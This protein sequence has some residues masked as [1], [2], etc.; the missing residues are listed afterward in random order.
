M[1]EETTM[2]FMTYFWKPFFIPFALSYLHTC[3]SYSMWEGTIQ[4]VGSLWSSQ[5]SST[6]LYETISKTN[7]QPLGNERQAQYTLICLDFMDTH[8]TCTYIHI[9][10]WRLFEGTCNKF[11]T[12]TDSGVRVSGLGIQSRIVILFVIHHFVQFDLHIYL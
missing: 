5:K 8:N 3:Q 12:E 7:S 11:P 9:C 1:Q 10:V 6:V 2:L 4:Q